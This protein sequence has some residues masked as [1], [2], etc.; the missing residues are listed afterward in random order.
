MKKIEDVLDRMTDILERL[1]STL[2]KHA[3]GMKEFSKVADSVN[4]MAST[5]IDVQASAKK[6]GNMREELN[7][8]IKRSITLRNAVYEKPEEK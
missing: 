5:F 6:M 3:N 7:N 4:L 1:D 8:E 2:N